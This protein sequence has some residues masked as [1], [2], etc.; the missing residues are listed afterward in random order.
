MATYYIPTDISGGTIQ[1]NDGDIFIFEGSASSDVKFESATG[2]PTNFFIEFN[3]SNSNL[4]K[5]EIKDDLNAN[6]SIADNV[7]LD[8][9]EIKADKSLSTDIN[10]G[11]N[12]TLDKFSGSDKGSDTIA[13]GDDFTTNNDFKTNGGNDY[14]TVGENFDSGSTIDTGNGNDTVVTRDPN[15]DITNAE[16]VLEPDGT[17]TGTSGN[18][19][20]GVGYSDSEADEIDGWDG[21][22]DVILGLGGNDTITGGAGNDTIDGGTGNDSIDGGAGADTI[23]GGIGND[24]INGGAGDDSILGGNGDDSISGG[25]GNDTIHGDEGLLPPTFTV[26]YIDINGATNSAE[27]TTLD[28]YFDMTDG[29]IDVVSNGTA[30]SGAVFQVNAF[31]TTTTDDLDPEIQSQGPP[32]GIGYGDTSGHALVYSTQ[33]NIAGGTYTFD[34]DFYNSAALYIDGQQVFISESFG[35][36]TASGSVTLTAGPHDV[37]IL[38]A[39]DIGGVQ[40]D[41]NMSISGGEF[42]STPIPFQNAP[43]F[44]TA[45][46]GGDDTID[47][48]AGD[49]SIQGGS[50]DDSIVINDSFG[51]DTIVGGESGETNGDSIDGSGLT[52][53]VTVT[54]T[55]A[56]AGGIDNGSDTATFSQIEQVETGSGEDTIIGSTGDQDVIT[57]AGDDIVTT[58]GTGADTIQTGAGNDTITF[59]EGDSIDGGT[60]DD[61]FL[62]EDLGEPTNGTITIVGGEGGETADD[63]D[64]LT[65][66][67][68]TLQLGTFADL[69]TLVKIS[70]GLNVDGNETFHGSVTMDDGTILNF[71]EIENIICFTP[72]TRIATPHGKRDIATLRVGDLV[73]TRDHGLQPIRWI[74]QRTVPAIDRFAPIRIRPGVVTGQQRD[75]LVSPQHRMMF[76]GYRAELLFGQSE[77][78]VAAKHLVDGKYVTQDVGGDVTYIHMMFDN[79]EVVYAEGAATESFHPSDVGLTAISDPA[80]EELFALFPSLRANPNGYGKTARRCLKKYECELLI[81]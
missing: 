13:I 63:N 53:D 1:V 46:G 17:V 69:S 52:E 37:V 61:T 45:T 23:D 41:L 19:T 30:P 33:M 55:G 34:A 18:D 14:V 67:G 73:V 28:T 5:V 42:G 77:V 81:L 56:E 7:V 40:E 51:D 60:G 20:M 57:G 39:K 68:D 16:T 31:G 29:T 71:S 35:A 22:D 32:N 79:H 49:D 26:Q 25:A 11:D 21:D 38:Y 44:G 8:D 27:A 24:N 9:L 48:G 10:I 59:S 70:D 4:G 62:A 15:A 2:S 74:Q 80:R 66:E 6:I 47:G 54:F 50:G 43:A 78:L 76:Q 12:V 3:A 65:L 58:T 75:L 64:P 36:N 72:G